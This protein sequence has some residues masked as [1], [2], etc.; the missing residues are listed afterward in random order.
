VVVPPPLP[1]GFQTIV[2]PIEVPVDLPPVDLT[3]RFD[4]RDFSGIGV[5][6]GV[7]DGWEGVTEGGESGGQGNAPLPA[8]VVDEPPRALSS[9]RLRFPE[10][11]RAAGIQGFNQPGI[12]RVRQRGDTEEPLPPGPDAG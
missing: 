11:L 1:K 2:A 7:W 12:R 6:G 5:Q 3:D 10:A 8:G 9:P 4:P